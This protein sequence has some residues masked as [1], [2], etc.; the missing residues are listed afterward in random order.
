MLEINN[1]INSK[2][3]LLQNAV[4]IFDLDDTLYSEKDYVRS[5]FREISRHYKNIKNMSDKLWYAFENG[6]KAIDSVLKEE[7]LH[8]PET[9]SRCLDLYRNHYP[10]ITI[11]PEAEKLLCIL[12]SNGVRL[13]MITDGRPEGQRAKI[14]ALGIQQY[15]EKI[16]I[17]DELGGIGFRKPDTKAFEE[18]QKHFNTPYSTMV[19]V[20]D[21]PKKD[22]IAPEKLGMNSVYFKN[23]RGL[24]FDPTQLG[25]E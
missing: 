21:N 24:Y 2:E 23:P 11:Y 19:Y 22:F 20:G 17:T 15:F 4:V 12:K 16:I 14:A 6:E 3:Y 9:V 18:M 10:D 13:G 1:L 8:S 25:S 5:G 7:G